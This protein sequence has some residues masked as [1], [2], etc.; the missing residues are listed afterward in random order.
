MSSTER[1]LDAGGHQRSPVTMPGY[2]LPV[3]ALF[4]VLHG[5]T[6]GR[7][8]EASAARKQLRRTAEAAGVRRRFSPHQ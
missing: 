5:P 7:R 1:L 3:G 8:W 6:A 2:H 4:C